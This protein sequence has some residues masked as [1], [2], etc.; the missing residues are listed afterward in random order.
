[1]IRT[2]LAPMISSSLRKRIAMNLRTALLNPFGIPNR[3]GMRAVFAELGKAVLLT[4]LLA[5][6]ATQVADAQAL[7]EPGLS[8]DPGWEGYRNRLLPA[9]RPLTRQD[10]GY[11]ATQH[12]GGEAAGEIGGW[13]QRSLTPANYAMKLPR[14]LSLDDH[15]VASGK[16]AVSHNSGASGVLI[17]WF[18]HTSRSWRTTNSLAFRADGNGDTYWLFVE[19]GTRNGRTGG[20]GAFEGERYQTTKTMPFPADGSTH[21]WRLEYDPNGNEGAGSVEFRIDDRTYEFD[22]RPEDREDGALFDRFGIWNQETTGDGMRIWLDDLVING[23]K[24]SFDEDPEWDAVGNR[25]EFSEDTVRPFHDFG[26]VAAAEDGSS[27]GSIG[28]IIWRDERPSYY[29]DRVGPLSLDNELYAEGTVRF[30]ASGPDSAVYLGWFDSETKQNKAQPEYETR[31]RNYLGILLEGPSRVGH[32]FRPGYATQSG[33]GSN[34]ERG[35]VLPVD[36]TK[37]KWTLRYD[38][39]AANERGVITVTLD[40]EQVSLELG[41]GDRR[42]GAT[43]D[44]FGLFNMQSGGWHVKA[45]F[46]DL[47]YSAAVE[48]VRP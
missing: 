23:S 2:S 40:E 28:G 39:H 22:V 26:V 37:H 1:M 24:Q 41:E 45:Y 35:P 46:D 36:N 21:A 18:H 47:R 42:E 48:N 32:Y 5:L 15:L 8:V 9:E 7:R 16:M 38:P 30:V 4:M 13:V 10:F 44:R 11:R 25:T 31:Q 3:H 14:E 33:D 6:P 19:Y 12:A 43:F 34:A 20:I 29:A 17:G 27:G